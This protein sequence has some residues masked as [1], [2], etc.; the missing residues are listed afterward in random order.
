M[1]VACRDHTEVRNPPGSALSYDGQPR[2]AGPPRGAMTT[3]PPGGTPAPGGPATSQPFGGVGGLLIPLL[4]LVLVL[5]AALALREVAP[6][7]VPVVFGLFLALVAWPMVGA[8]ERRGLRHGAALTGSI[9]AVV[10]IVVAV[11]GI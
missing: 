3:R 8:M 10:A 5:V 4:V 11:T 7:V 9:L 1:R 2:A 6:L